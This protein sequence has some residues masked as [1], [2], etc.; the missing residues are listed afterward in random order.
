MSFLPRILLAFGLFLAVAAGAHAAAA[1]TVSQK[2]KAFNVATLSAK[3]GDSIVFKNEDTVVH[4]LFTVGSSYAVNLVEQPGETASM[5]L[6]K[7]GDVEVRCAI[8]PTM[9]LKVHV[10]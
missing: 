8:H 4:N 6:D 2:A 7:S 9:V 3:R 5:T 10:E 1:H